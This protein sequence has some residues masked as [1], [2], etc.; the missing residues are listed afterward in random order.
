MIDHFVYNKNIPDAIL[1][2][3]K[4]IALNALVTEVSG[5]SRGGGEGEFLLIMAEH[6][7]TCR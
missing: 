3:N 1:I 7:S 4:R 6:D 2:Q 5:D